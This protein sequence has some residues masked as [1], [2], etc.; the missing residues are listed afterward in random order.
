MTPK[1]A[2]MNVTIINRGPEPVRVLAV[3]EAMLRDEAVDL[4]KPGGQLVRA[5]ESKAVEH[6]ASVLVRPGEEMA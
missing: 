2:A 3:T 5:G 4:A 1:T 6:D